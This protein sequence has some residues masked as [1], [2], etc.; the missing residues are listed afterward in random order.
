VGK[1]FSRSKTYF[2]FLSKKYKEMSGRPPRPPPP[3]Q[4]EPEDEEEDDEEL[5]DFEEVDMFD[6]LGGLLATEEGETVAT[7]LVGLKD[8]AEKI[9]LNLEMQNK[10]LVKIAAAVQ[11]M[12]PCACT[13]KEA[14]SA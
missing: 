8:A 7:A 13:E 6:A 4:E 14:P 3:R 11:K 12:T 10:I 9:A 1:K 2:Y 5:E